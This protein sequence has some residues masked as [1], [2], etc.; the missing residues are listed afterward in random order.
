MSEAEVARDLHEV[1]AKVQQG[2][3]V[4]IEQDH[5]PVAVIKAPQGP[6]RMI[7]ECI[8]LAKAYEEK[9]G[10]APVPDADFAKDVQA[11]ID[12]HREPLNPPAW[13]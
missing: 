7:S 8:A 1:L 3:E 2:V 12:A 6:G 11:A 5:R 4:V 9:L 10:Y 13:D